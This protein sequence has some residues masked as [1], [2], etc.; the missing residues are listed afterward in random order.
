MTI[1]KI[2]ERH[3]PGAFTVEDENG[4]WFFIQLAHKIEE[5]W[6]KTQKQIAQS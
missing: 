6:K 5:Q 2:I 4:N 1:S 3:S